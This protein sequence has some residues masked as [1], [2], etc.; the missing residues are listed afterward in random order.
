MSW[1]ER[2]ELRLRFKLCDL[3]SDCGAGKGGP[4]EDADGGTEGEEGLGI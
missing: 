1:K 4:N 3:G 2:V